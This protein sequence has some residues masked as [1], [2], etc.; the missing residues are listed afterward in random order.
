MINLNI[1]KNF[2]S[3]INLESVFQLRKN[4]FYDTKQLGRI[5]V[6]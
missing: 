1:F 3:N 5:L 6:L 2:W 4:T